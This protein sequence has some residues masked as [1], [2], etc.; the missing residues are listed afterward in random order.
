MLCLV[1]ALSALQPKDSPEGNVFTGQVKVVDRAA[2]KD[3][4]TDRFNDEQTMILP[5]VEKVNIAWPAQLKQ[6]N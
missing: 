5:K 2:P 6:I 1:P 3:Q 4:A